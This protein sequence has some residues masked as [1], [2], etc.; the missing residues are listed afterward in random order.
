M[1][2]R[3]TKVTVTYFLP[4]DT[5][6]RDPDTERSYSVTTDDAGIGAIIAAMDDVEGQ[7]GDDE[8]DEG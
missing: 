3:Q 4:D 2:S 6:D 5:D 1:N 7:G 8:D